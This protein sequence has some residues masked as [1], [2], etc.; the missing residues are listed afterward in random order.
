MGKVNSLVENT[1]MI[2]IS[3]SISALAWNLNQSMGW[4]HMNKDY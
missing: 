1:T 3:I 4:H 2:N